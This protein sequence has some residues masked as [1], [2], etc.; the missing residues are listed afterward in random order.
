VP[1]IH[2]VSPV[3]AQNADRFTDSI[4]N[5]LAEMT[6]IS[7][8]LRRDRELAFYGSEDL[9]PSEF[10]TEQDA[11]AACNQARRVHDIVTSNLDPV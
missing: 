5:Q 2:D 7:K 4:R 3:L 6:R 11:I 9:T 1:K 10:Y 8:F